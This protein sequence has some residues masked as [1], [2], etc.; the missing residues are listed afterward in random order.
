[1]SS[2]WM[3]EPDGIE[4]A[5]FKIHFDDGSEEIFKVLAGSDIVDWINESGSINKVGLE[6][7]GWSGK[8]GKGRTAYISELNWRNPNPDKLITKIDFISNKKRSGP[9]LLVITLE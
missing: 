8:N 9:F 7:I 5:N 4:V 3:R 1:M 6:K 2:I